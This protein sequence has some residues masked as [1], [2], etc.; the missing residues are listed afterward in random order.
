MS[1]VS[2]PSHKS[3]FINALCVAR[4]SKQVTTTISKTMNLSDMTHGDARQ[5]RDRENDLIKRW[6]DQCI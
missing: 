6:I 4:V 3:A 5:V 2:I 1:A